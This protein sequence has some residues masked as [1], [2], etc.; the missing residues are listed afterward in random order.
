MSDELTATAMIAPLVVAMVEAIKRSGGPLIP[1]RV[2]PLVSIAVAL[3]LVWIVPPV[4][5]WREELLTALIAGLT[6]SGLYSGGKAVS[7]R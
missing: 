5:G 7:G 6:A 4:V 1:H 2:M 3:M